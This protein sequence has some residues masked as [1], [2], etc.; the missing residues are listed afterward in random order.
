MLRPHRFAPALRASV[1]SYILLAAAL[2]FP[3]P[4]ARAATLTAGDL[5]ILDAYQWD[6]SNSILRVDPNTGTPIETISSAGL[7]TDPSGILVTPLGEILVADRNAGIIK[8][9]PATG[10]QTVFVAPAAL[11]GA[12]PWGI[13]REASGNFVVVCGDANGIWR[14]S[15]TGT[16]LG[17]FSAHSRIFGASAITVGPTGTL[18]VADDGGQVVSVDP[19]S[20]MQTVLN[21]TGVSFWGPDAIA[22]GKTGSPVYV[23]M[24]G[25]FSYHLGGGAWSIDPVS[26]VGAR[27]PGSFSWVE[28]V[29]VDPVSGDAYIPEVDVINHD[30]PDWAQ[31]IK[32]VNGTWSVITPRFQMLSGLIA[33]VPP[34]FASPAVPITWGRLKAMMR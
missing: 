8:I 21:V 2:A 31:I 1:I 3:A 18:W 20:G 29:A 24:R 32:S 7:L 14:V 33:V 5:V 30:T 15:P 22:I 10:V 6:H 4:P 17:A 11:G 19:T 16:V 12:G 34:Q 13:A 26:G 9:D 28:G 27:V 23:N 25:G